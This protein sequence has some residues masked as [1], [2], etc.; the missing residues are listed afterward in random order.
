MGNQC[1]KLYAIRLNSS[2]KNSK[3]G[4]GYFLAHLVYTI[5]HNNT[6]FPRETIGPYLNPYYLVSNT[7][8]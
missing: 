4:G 3:I 7:L 1:I 5:L 8:Q 6:M 2:L